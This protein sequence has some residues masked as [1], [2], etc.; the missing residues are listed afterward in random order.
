MCIPILGALK[1]ALDVADRLLSVFQ[2]A[3]Q[4][5]AGRNEVELEGANRTIRDLEKANE[6]DAAGPPTDH[7]R[8]LHE[9]L[10]PTTDGARRD[11]GE[12]HPSPSRD[13]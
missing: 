10:P 8:L 12:A 9:L 11:L 2:A 7:G 6:I 4:R 13:S 5:E 1:G 3:Q